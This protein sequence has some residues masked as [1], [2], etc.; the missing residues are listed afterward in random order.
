[1]I[2]VFRIFRWFFSSTLILMKKSRR[3]ASKSV[4]SITSPAVWSLRSSWQTGVI[5]ETSATQKQTYQLVTGAH[6]C[7]YTHAH[8]HRWEPCSNCGSAVPL[9]CQS[10]LAWQPAGIWLFTLHH[11]NISSTFSSLRSTGKKK[12]NP[13]PPASLQTHT[14]T[15][16]E[17]THPTLLYTLSSSLRGVYEGKYT[18]LHTQ[19]RGGI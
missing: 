14:H 9:Q 10:H 6:T 15:R 12:K 17:R 8:T 5:S 16:P 3:A 13:K 1:M 7:T 11:I 18:H 19:N 2:F 4:P